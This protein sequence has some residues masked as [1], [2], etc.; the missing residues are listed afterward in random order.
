MAEMSW[1]INRSHVFKKTVWVIHSLIYERGGL[2]FGKY[3]LFFYRI[4]IS[5]NSREH[6]AMYEDLHIYT[7]L[8]I[9]RINFKYH[10]DM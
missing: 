3:L 7:N 2:A 6:S 1:Y 9:T 10:M 8:I 4:S 5:N